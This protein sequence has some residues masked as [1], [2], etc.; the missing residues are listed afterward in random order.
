[1]VDIYT[2]PSELSHP[3]VRS[4]Y[5]LERENAALRKLYHIVC[6]ELE[7]LKR[8]NVSSHTNTFNGRAVVSVADAASARGVSV[9]T[10]YRYLETDHWQ[11]ASKWIDKKRRWWVY[12]DQ[13][14]TRKRKVV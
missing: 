1:M 6:A 5:D 8:E 3:A 2:P 11:G 7:T 13:P 4:R 14:F 10:V 9:A 12:A